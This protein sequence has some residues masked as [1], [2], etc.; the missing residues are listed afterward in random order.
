MAKQK[1]LPEPKECKKFYVTWVTAINEGRPKTDVGKELDIDDAEI[2][3]LARYCRTI[4]P[5]FPAFSKGRNGGD[6][7]AQKAERK[8]RKFHDHLV[9]VAEDLGL[10]PDDLIADKKAEWLA[11]FTDTE[12]A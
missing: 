8:V 9:A 3:R 7:P 2:E 5:D 4:Y 1:G 10:N 6:T 11:D 12:A